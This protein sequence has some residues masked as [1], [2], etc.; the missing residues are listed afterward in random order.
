[1]KYD[2]NRSTSSPTPHRTPSLPR[3]SPSLLTPNSFRSLLKIPNF[4][5]LIRYVTMS[6][7]SLARPWIG[8]G[9]IVREELTLSV[10]G[11]PLERYLHDTHRASVGVCAR[12]GRR[13]GE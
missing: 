6:D 7:Q 5:R 2:S 12:C 1:M 9:V 4:G 8:T 11:A 10:K 13:L 3:P